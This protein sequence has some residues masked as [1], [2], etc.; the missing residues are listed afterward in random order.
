[1]TAAVLEP[2]LIAPPHRPQRKSIPV[3][4]RLTAVW[5]LLFLNVLEF[6]RYPMVLPIPTVLGK[7]VTQ[8]SLLFALLLVLT[9]N[10]RLV[11]RPNIFLTMLTVMA[12]VA[13]AVSIRGYFGVGSDVRAIRLLGFVAMLWLTSPWWGRADMALLHAHRRWLLIAI[14]TVVVGAAIAPGKA[15]YEGRL[16]G[17]IWPIPPTQVAHYCALAVGITAVLWLSGQGSTR[18]S[19]TIMGIA[20]LVLLLTHTRTAL[21][22]LVAGLIVASA[23]LFLARSRVRQAILIA[24]IVCAVVGLTLLPILTT[25]LERG[26]NLQEL[27]EF[28]GRTNVWHDLLTLP[29]TFGHEV[30]GFGLSNKSFGGLPIDDS[31]LATYQDLGL[32]GDI[33]DGL[34]LVTLF[35]FAFMRPRGP[36]KAVALFLITYCLVASF[37]EVGLGDASP[38]LLDLTIAASLVVPPPRRSVMLARRA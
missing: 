33:M 19:W 27:S 9:L 25:F 2:T 37:T 23:S 15:F 21:L 18:R 7:L 10:R 38:Y 13:F 11:F 34:M 8:A 16:D 28:T 5:G 17:A 31:W 3:G 24:V 6:L 35:T 12:T 36:E 1:M 32:F 29:R 4:W 14:G 26:Q 22:A 30:F 20:T